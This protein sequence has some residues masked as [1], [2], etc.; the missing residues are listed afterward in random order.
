MNCVSRSCVLI[1]CPDGFS[2]AAWAGVTHIGAVPF[3]A[4]FYFFAN[5]DPGTPTVPCWG[6]PSP[7]TRIRGTRRAV[8]LSRGP[9]LATA[10]V[11]FSGTCALE[12]AAAMARAVFSRPPG[13]AFHQEF[14]CGPLRRLPTWPLGPPLAAC[15]EDSKAG[16]S[17]PFSVSSDTEVLGHVSQYAKRGLGPTHLH[18]S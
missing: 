17:A 15:S 8:F 16:L 3:L 14:S 18:L 2:G 12:G 4:S 5:P 6:T 7:G 10:A 11:P 9:G 13:R 1:S